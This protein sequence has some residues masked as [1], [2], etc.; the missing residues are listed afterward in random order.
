M[1]TTNQLTI[2]KL[3]PT[4]ASKATEWLQQNFDK[5]TIKPLA[6]YDMGAEIASAMMMITEAKDRNGKPALEVCS[7]ESVISSLRDMAIQGLSMVRKQCYPIVYGNQLQIQRSYFG[8]IA[9]FS[10]M[11]PNLKPVANILYEG[12]EYDYGYDDVGDFNYIKVTK[13][14]LSN[15]DK[16]IVAAYGYIVDKTTREKVYGC[17]MTANEI[18]KSWSKSRNPGQSVHKDFPQEMAKRTLLNRMVK[19][20]VNGATNL[21]PVMAE[22]YMRTLDNEF[23]NEAKAPEMPQEK[24]KAIRAKSQGAE[25]LKSLLKDEPEP[26]KAKAE[27]TELASATPEQ[28]KGVANASDEKKGE[29][30]PP[31]ESKEPTATLEEQGFV[32][33]RELDSLFEPDEIPEDDP[34]YGPIPF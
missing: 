28:Q 27:Y 24:A 33:Q 9:V 16:K 26:Q 13:T 8:T 4:L 29:T 1:A 17:V 5:G 2:A 10:R 19:L 25:G 3:A 34:E 12:D 6:G 32:E 30:I 23:E 14:S 21:E 15:R 7:Q 31:A 18:A 22:A 20:Y 11:F